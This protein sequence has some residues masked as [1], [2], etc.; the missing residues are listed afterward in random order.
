MN[1]RLGILTM[2]KLMARDQAPISTASSERQLWVMLSQKAWAMLTKVGEKERLC[3]NFLIS[4]LVIHAEGEN[5]LSNIARRIQKAGPLHKPASQNIGDQPSS[6]GRMDC[7]QPEKLE[8]GVVPS[9]VCTPEEGVIEDQQHRGENVD[10]EPIKPVPDER[11]ESGDAGAC[12]SHGTFGER[13]HDQPDPSA[14]GTDIDDHRFAT[15]SR[16]NGG[17]GIAEETTFHA[18]AEGRSPWTLPTKMPKID[19]DD[20]YDPISDRFWNEIW[21]A[22]AVHNVGSS[23]AFVS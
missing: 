21:N 20:F 10:A 16:P 13:P 11:H 23:F 19:P 17:E 6:V 1:K 3:R 15:Q 9:L 4:P 8:T 2:S 22:N 5:A 18:K 7:T 12:P 14:T